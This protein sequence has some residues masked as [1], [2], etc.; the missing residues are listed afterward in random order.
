[1]VEQSLQRNAETQRNAGGGLRHD[2]E[3][4]HGP[5]GFDVPTVLPLPRN[6]V[7]TCGRGNRE[8]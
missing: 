8:W 6:P 2:A 5:T 3:V 1:M 7:M 4:D